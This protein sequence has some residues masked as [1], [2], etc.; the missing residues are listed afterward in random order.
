[1]NR[2]HLREIDGEKIRMQYFIWPILILLFCMFFVPY[3]M[4]V[5]SLGAEDFDFSN[6]L[7]TV[8][9]S[10]KICLVFAIPFVILSVLNRHC[11]GKI[12][13]VISPSGIHYKDGLVKWEDITKVEYE[14]EL[15]G[16]VPKLER[17]FCHAIIYTKK[18]NI[19]LV[20]A[21]MFFISKIKKHNPLFDVKISKSSKWMIGFLI[22]LFIFAI[23][24]I[25]L[26]T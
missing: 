16:G 6:W 3:C 25:P 2:S 23:P 8:F 10:V 15:P 1:M 7:S 21:P 11:F 5:F 12:I 13:C 14:I 18:E 24:L 22:V 17:L 20:H 26:F 9:V 19:K 4:L